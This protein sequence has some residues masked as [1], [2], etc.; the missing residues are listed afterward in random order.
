[1]NS[2]GRDACRRCCRW[3]LFPPANVSKGLGGRSRR[4]YSGG[5]VMLCE[6]TV[7]PGYV[8][9]DKRL[10]K[11][12]RLL[13]ALRPRRAST[14][15]RKSSCRFIP[16][17]PSSKSSNTGSGWPGVSNNDRKKPRWYAS[18]SPVQGKGQGAG[19]TIWLVTRVCGRLCRWRSMAQTA[20][21]T[22]RASVCRN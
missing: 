2:D 18:S 7:E 11:H 19:G 14:G 22:A 6:I 21:N 16:Q 1:M 13:A 10:R 3:N 8:R 5:A 12:D 9:A 4:K 15:A 20:K 17:S